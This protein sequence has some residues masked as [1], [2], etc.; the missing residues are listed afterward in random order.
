MSTWD[1]KYKRNLAAYDEQIKK[2]FADNDTL[3]QGMKDSVQSTYEGSIA[4]QNEGYEELSRANEVQKYINAREVAENNANLGLTDSGLNRTQQTAVQLSASNEEARIQRARQSAVAALTRE[5]NAKLA[6]IETSRLSSRSSIQQGYEKLASD[7][8]T[9][10]YKADVE[11]ETARVKAQQDTKKEDLSKLVEHLKENSLDKKYCA[12]LIDE[13]AYKYGIDDSSSEMMALLKIPD[14]TLEDLD[15]AV[16][17]NISDNQEYIPLQKRKWAVVSNGGVNGFMGLGKLFGNI[18]DNATV[19]DG[20]NT[21]TMA[22][23]S[24]E[25]QKEGLSREDAKNWIVWL[26]HHL[27]VH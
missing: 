27:G 20:E 14:I 11:A 12:K 23:L 17:G 4:D 24:E 22:K 6:D 18:D 15:D 2:Q 16:L 8:A 26:Q 21:Y 19:T 1:E 25:L 5:M 9:S 10:A 7:A 13:Y 3:H